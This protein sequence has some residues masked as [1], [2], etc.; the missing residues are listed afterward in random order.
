MEKLILAFP[1]ALGAILIAAGLCVIIY[2][3]KAGIPVSGT[4]TDIAKSQKKY[5]RVKIA[6][7]APVVKYELDGETISAV[8]A[9]FFAEGTVSFR[10]GQHIDIRV[11]R[12][13][14]RK[15]VPE[16]GGGIAGKILIACGLVMSLGCIVMILRYF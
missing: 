4:V 6:L 13:N 14:K 15:F 12:R 5:S 7:E 11:S 3:K 16:E 1:V 8:S 2:R 10:K 9:K